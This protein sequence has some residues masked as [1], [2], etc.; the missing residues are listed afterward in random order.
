[1][2]YKTALFAVPRDAFADA[3]PQHRGPLCGCAKA[4]VDNT[5][6]CESDD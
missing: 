3:A 5:F 2:S 4:P 6:T 1:M